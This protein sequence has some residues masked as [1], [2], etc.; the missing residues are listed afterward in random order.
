MAS[1]EINAFHQL[2]R[3]D[4]IKNIRSLIKSGTKAANP[5]ALNFRSQHPSYQGVPQNNSGGFNRPF[6]G[7]KD[8]SHISLAD[9]I[10]LRGGVLKNFQYAQSILSRRADD[11]RNLQL[12]QQ[13][14]PPQPTTPPVLSE[15][16]SRLLDFNNTLRGLS[17]LISQ[18]PA[19]VSGITFLEFNKLPRQLVQLVPQM[20]PTQITEIIRF[21]DSLEAQLVEYEDGNIDLDEQITETTEVKQFNRL[22]VPAISLVQTMM[23]FLRRYMEFATLDEAGRMKAAGQLA[24]DVFGLKKKDLIVSKRDQPTQKP[25]VEAPEMEPKQPKI[26]IS[27]FVNAIPTDETYRIANA[28]YQDLE[29][30]AIIDPNSINEI[31]GTLKDNLGDDYYRAITK[32]MIRANYAPG[33]EVEGVMQDLNTMG[34]N[35]PFSIRKTSRVTQDMDPREKLRLAKLE[36]QKEAEAKALREGRGRKRSMK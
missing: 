28:L 19:G 12:V 10:A 34:I 21:L 35:I 27:Q 15:L 24:K 31:R 4:E 17:D 14:Q 33:L 32:Q 2:Q 1:P 5:A 25:D 36:E 11:L 13:G 23:E 3:Q 8:E 16:D 29:N 26:T 9:K 20:T 6:F 18:G 30:K 7:N 22:L